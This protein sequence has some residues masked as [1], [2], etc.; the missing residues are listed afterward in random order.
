[1]DIVANGRRNIDRRNPVRDIA[2]EGSGSTSPCVEKGNT[3][4][5]LWSRKSF[6]VETIPRYVPSECGF[7]F[8]LVQITRPSVVTACFAKKSSFLAPFRNMIL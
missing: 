3:F 8:Q 1:M 7:L 6:V 5:L 4:F 2:V